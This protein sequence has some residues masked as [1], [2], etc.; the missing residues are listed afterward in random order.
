[1]DNTRIM[2]EYEQEQN[3][4]LVGEAEGKI[5]GLPEDLNDFDDNVINYLRDISVFVHQRN[6][7][8]D[9]ISMELMGSREEICD[10]IHGFRKAMKDIHA[11][12][13]Y[14]TAINSKDIFVS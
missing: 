4:S 9:I 7:F 6:Y 5:L 2:L 1:M 13:I 11:I 8:V 3:N 14:K 12:L 10:T